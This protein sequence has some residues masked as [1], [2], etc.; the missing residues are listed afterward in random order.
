[1]KWI[2]SI[3]ILSGWLHAVAQPAGNTQAAWSEKGERV[4]PEQPSV[5][6]QTGLAEH[7]SDCGN[8]IRIAGETNLSSFSLRQEVTNEYICGPDNSRWIHNP[9]KER[10]EVMIPVKQFRATNRMVYKDFLDLLQVEKHPEIVLIIPDEE[11]YS[12]YNP[13]SVVPTKVGIRVAGVT[14]FYRIRC[15][16]IPCVPGDLVITGEKSLKLTDF[17]LE[18]PVKSLGM[19]RVK[20]E[21]IVNFEFRLPQPPN[22]K[23]TQR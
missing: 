7:R 19:I 16:V 13:G 22:Q 4:Y 14:R 12:L 9:G 20:N 10:Y 8:T 18:P 3:A 2:L 21:L 6:P 5:Q 17:K 15:R 11:F 23:L 1:M